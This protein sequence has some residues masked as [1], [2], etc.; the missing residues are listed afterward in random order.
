MAKARTWRRYRGWIAA[1]VLVVIAAAAFFA[2]RQSKAAAP[3]ETYQTEQVSSGTLS[4]TVS[5]TGNL[6]VDGTTD[7]YPDTAG[8]VASIAVA[9]GDA[10]STGTVLFR[11]DSEDAEANT[12]S[13][14]ASYRRAQQSV[15]QAEAQ[16]LKAENTLDELE[17]RYATQTSGG[18]TSASATGA[19][20][21]G[22]TTG[23]TA[24]GATTG[25]TGATTGA[26]TTGTTAETQV[27]QADIDAAQADVTS[28]EA[29]L[30]SAKADRSSAAIAYETAES[31]EDDLAV[32]SPCA[33]VIHSLDIEVGDTVSASSGGSSTTGSGG[34]TAG[35]A[36][37]GGTTTTG[38]TSSS[39]PIV[40]APKQPLALV[41][42]IN[43]VDLPS[44][45]VGQRADIEFDAL[46]DLTAT[47]KVIE[48]A[49]E[50]T[51]NSGVVTYDVT[52]SL[53][54]A[55]PAL[56]SGMSS[57][58]TI[59]TAVAKDALL[60]SNAVVKSNTDG[61][62]YVLVMEPGATTPTQVTVETGLSS[63][64]QTQILSGLEVGQTVVT[65]TS[66]SSGSDT[67]EDS[68]SGGGIMM[69]GMGGGPGPGGPGE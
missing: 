69:P 62:S 5:G 9:E 33:G 28:A 48:I 16:L 20:A 66:T 35:G 38:S 64:T 61:T 49:D 4:V 57:A 37:S 14:L 21:T 18:S 2:F 32:T 27:T 7:V 60:V 43:E 53:D 31:A 22:T 13:A 65:Q 8:T 55:D 56:R 47:G 10:V 25:A 3:T 1:G 15:A 50:G 34:S 23:A 42:A 63:S 12:A 44:L 29:S 24:T 58:A 19:T 54:D 45:K 59:V 40:I 41:L 17:E 68:D 11:L 30:A 67:S 39:A 51:V 6:T 52:L 46:P 26:T 36:T